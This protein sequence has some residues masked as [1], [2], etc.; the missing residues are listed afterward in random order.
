[1]ILPVASEVKVDGPPVNPLTLY[2][3]DADK[4]D[5]VTEPFVALHSVGSTF[6]KEKL[7]FGQT[8][9]ATENVEP[10]QVPDLGVTV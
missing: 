2:D 4:P 5:K 3:V 8:V 7:G 6:D 1:V 10:V 9:T